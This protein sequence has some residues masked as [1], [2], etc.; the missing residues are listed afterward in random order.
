MKLCNCHTRIHTPAV[1]DA[2][3]GT[4]VKLHPSPP[5]MALLWVRSVTKSH[6]CLLTWF[7]GGTV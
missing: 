5:F 2:L 4:R 1:C 7:K 6:Y 3:L